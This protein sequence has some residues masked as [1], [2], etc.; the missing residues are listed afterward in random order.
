[1]AEGL[2][3]MD[4][5]VGRIWGGWLVELYCFLYRK[6]ELYQHLELL[7]VCSFDFSNK[8][9]TKRFWSRFVFKDRRVGSWAA[10]SISVWDVWLEGGTWPAVLAALSKG[11]GL[12]TLVLTPCRG[13]SPVS[14]V[15]G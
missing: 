7:P 2:T 13:P 1:M 5:V 9:A 15:Q 14:K 3:V 6:F 12:R 4:T 11:A 8:D 10:W